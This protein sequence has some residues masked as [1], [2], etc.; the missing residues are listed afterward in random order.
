MSNTALPPDLSPPQQALWW[1]RKGDFKLGPA[2]DMAHALCQQAEGTFEYDLVHALAHWIE[3][4]MG[5]RDY[6]YG[7][8]GRDWHRA[9][10]IEQEF[11]RIATKLGV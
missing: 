3:G 1:L 4:D 10:S 5:N 2:W 8:V 11:E 9:Q 7:R 6:W